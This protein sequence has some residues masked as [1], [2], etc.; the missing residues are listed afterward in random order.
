MNEKKIKTRYLAFQIFM[1]YEH[2]E[3]Q[4]NKVIFMN[5]IKK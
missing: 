4:K 1:K 3:L 5:K 2:T